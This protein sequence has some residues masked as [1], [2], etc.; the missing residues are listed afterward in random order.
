[1]YDIILYVLVG[2]IGTLIRL[3]FGIAVDSLPKIA[4]GDSVWN[5]DVSNVGRDLTITRRFKTIF[6]A[7][8]II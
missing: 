2:Q 7:P 4:F 1:M 5:C 3:T 6:K 8:S